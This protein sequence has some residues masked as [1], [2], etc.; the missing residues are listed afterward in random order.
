LWIGGA[1]CWLLITLWIRVYN[2]WVCVIKTFFIVG[3]FGGGGLE[4]AALLLA[5][6]EALLLVATICFQQLCI[7]IQSFIALLTV[8][9]RDNK[10][11]LVAKRLRRPI[12]RC[13]WYF[14]MK[15]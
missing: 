6:C 13:N 15:H 3:G 8:A 9:S 12:H 4:L 7:R 10:M 1:W 11:E 2:S 14:Q 5:P